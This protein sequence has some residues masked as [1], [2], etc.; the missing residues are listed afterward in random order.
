MGFDSLR[1]VKALRAVGVE[2]PVAEAHAE[3]A[4]DAILAEVATKDDLEH[5]REHIER[6]VA[7]LR[8]EVGGLREDLGREVGGLRGELGREVG[9][10]REEFTR[11]IKLSEARQ[12]TKVGTMLAVAVGLLVA[13]DRLLS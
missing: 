3:L 6:D 8:R 4:R 12:T 9:G 1:F 10:L 7:E 2:Q 11:E 5:L 13:L